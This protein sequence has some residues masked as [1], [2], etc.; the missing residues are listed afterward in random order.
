MRQRGRRRDRLEVFY[1]K[2]LANKSRNKDAT[3][4]YFHLFQKF[5]YTFYI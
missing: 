4:S 1:E 3:K 2:S 5:V